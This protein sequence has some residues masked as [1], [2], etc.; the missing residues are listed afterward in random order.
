MTARHRR[1]CR[2]LVE[3]LSRFIDNDL[4]AAERLAVKRHLQRCPC[5]DDFVASLA[6]TVRV[7]QEAGHVEL[8]PAVKAR[9]VARVR[10]LIAQESG[11]AA[12]RTAR[13]GGSPATRPTTRTSRH[14]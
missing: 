13:R 9:A 8:P 11:T 5:C 4:P 3:Q 6:R 12:A 7:C 2:E 1:D 14:K 10:M